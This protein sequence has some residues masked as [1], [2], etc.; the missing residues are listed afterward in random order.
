MASLSGCARQ[1][2]SMMRR[3]PVPSQLSLFDSRAGAKPAT[4]TMTAICLQSGSNGNCT[5]VETPDARILIDAG[6]PVSQTRLR[7]EE[8][9]RSADGL[10]GLLLTHD[11]GDHAQHAEAYHRELG[12]AVFGTWGCLDAVRRRFAFD[13]IKCARGFDPGASVAF[14]ETRVRSV[15]TPHDGKDGVAFVVTAGGKRLGVLTDLGH[16]FEELRAVVGSLDGVILESNYDPRMLSTGRY[17]AFLKRRIRGPRGHLSNE[18]AAE[19][20]R[21]HGSGRLSWVCLAHL[22]EA[23]NEPE[24]ALGVHRRIVGRGVCYYLASRYGMSEPMTL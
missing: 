10:D 2:V 18:E 9:G 14:G 4:T 15:P 7:L 23:N 20:I 6:I 1:V 17:P 5:Y 12:V 19:L 13:T 8:A 3:G 22:S 16:V 11:H 21:D 24:L